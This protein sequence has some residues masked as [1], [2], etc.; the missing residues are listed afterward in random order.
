MIP[1]L[2][3]DFLTE[4]EEKAYPSY[5]YRMEKSKNV[6]RGF[7]DG[8]QAVEQAIYKRLLTQQRQY[9]IYSADYGLD[10]KDMYGMPF[11]W[12]QAVLPD[13]IKESLSYDDRIT[14][15]D[16]FDL[17]IVDNHKL[18]ISFD[19]STVFGDLKIT[20]LEVMLDV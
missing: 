9:I 10:M 12:V 19:V 18:A 14:G 7:I 2:T 15:I 1:S 3:E 17:R 11:D 5:T 16:N 4:I 8:S 6:F 13:K 20:G